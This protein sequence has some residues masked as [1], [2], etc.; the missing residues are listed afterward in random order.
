MSKK[1][2]TITGDSALALEFGVTT[3]TVYS[4][5]MAGLPFKRE[6]R[7]YVY[8]RRQAE[9][10]VRIHRRP[11]DGISSDAALKVRLLIAE[12]QQRQERLKAAKMEREEAA[13]VSNILLRDEWDLFKVD[14]VRHARERFGRLGEILCR[15]VPA[16]C[17]RVL[18]SQCNDDVRKIIDEMDRY[19][20]MGPTE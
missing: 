4:W 10:F 3:K 19:L 17:R 5:R 2:Q 8:D 7:R 12:A 16:N 6:G 11:V 14:V 1:R 18:R 13:E 15:H 20:A 9:E